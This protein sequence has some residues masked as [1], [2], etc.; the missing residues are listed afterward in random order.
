MFWL[1]P[2]TWP[3]GVA[4]VRKALAPDGMPAS[5]RELEVNVAAGKAAG[6]VMVPV[7]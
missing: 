2:Y 3:N 4:A 6:M 1:L 7:Y 5:A